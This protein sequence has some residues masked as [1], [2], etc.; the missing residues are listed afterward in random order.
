MRTELERDLSVVEP[1]RLPDLGWMWREILSGLPEGAW[2]T[3]SGPFTRL[4]GTVPVYGA[5][6][7]TDTR[8]QTPTLQDRWRGEGETPEEALRAAEQAWIHGASDE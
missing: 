4:E 1:E 5:S 8:L 6:I 3:V 2:L 7:F